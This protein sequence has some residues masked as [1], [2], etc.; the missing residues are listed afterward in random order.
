MPR[1]CIHGDHLYGLSASLVKVIRL[2][3]GLSE[4]AET[5]A[6]WTIIHT[7]SMIA[8][9]LQGI[10]IGRVVSAKPAWRIGELSEQVETFTR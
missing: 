10:F 3:A 4:Y 6:G 5:S 1:G 8:R 7:V 9:I 2:C